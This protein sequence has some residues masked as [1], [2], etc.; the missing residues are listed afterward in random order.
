MVEIIETVCPDPTCQAKVSH[1][2]NEEHDRRAQSE[3]L[4]LERLSARKG[5]RLSKQSTI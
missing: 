4:K 3:A 1:I 2:L 5:I